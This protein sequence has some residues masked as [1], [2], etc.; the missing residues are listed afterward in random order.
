MLQ[1]GESIFTAT[2]PSSGASERTTRLLS[3]TKA[4]PFHDQIKA[5]NAAFQTTLSI[6]GQVFNRIGSLLPCKWQQPSFAQIYFIENETKKTERRT[7]VI[8]GLDKMIVM[9]LQDM[10]H[11]CNELVL[12]ARVTCKKDPGFMCLRDIYHQQKQFGVFLSLISTVITP[13][14]KQRKYT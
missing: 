9:E 6:Q 1:I 2:A 10:L 11:N 5:Y 12:V 13:L 14:F 4:V 8:S 3:L 7:T